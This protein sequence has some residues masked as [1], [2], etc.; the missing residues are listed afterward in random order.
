MQQLVS[1]TIRPVVLSD[2]AA[3]Q[4]ARI[5]HARHDHTGRHGCQ[6][7][8]AELETRTGLSSGQIDSLTAASRLPRHLNE[9]IPGA[10]DSTLGDQLADAHA[11]DAYDRVLQQ[12]AAETVP[13]LLSEL[14]DRENVIVKARFGVDGSEQTLQQLAGTLGVSAERVRQLEVRAMDKLRAIADSRRQVP[15]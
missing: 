15:R 6:A 5:N 1:E 11:E 13:R 10:G 12:L 3:R 14:D 7:S 8:T 4:L 2:R 9:P